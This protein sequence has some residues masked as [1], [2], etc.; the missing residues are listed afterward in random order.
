MHPAPEIIAAL[1][2]VES[3]L[4]EAR[5]DVKPRHLVKLG[6]SQINGCAHFVAL[7]T[8]EARGDG[9]SNERLDRLITWRHSPDYTDGERVALEWIEALTLVNSAADLTS[10]RDEVSNHF[11]VEKATV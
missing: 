7:H 3:A 11:G 6:A 5:L 10:L 8:S 1:Q 9:E 2:A 4:L